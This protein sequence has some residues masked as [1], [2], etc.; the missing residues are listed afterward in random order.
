MSGCGRDGSQRERSASASVSP[1]MHQCIQLTSVYR[2]LR[3]RTIQSRTIHRW[4]WLRHSRRSLQSQHHPRMHHE[5]IPVFPSVAAE[6]SRWTRLRGGV[7]R[8]YM[9]RQSPRWTR[10]RG[11]GESESVHAFSTV[12]HAF[13]TVIHAFTT[14]PRSCRQLVAF[15][16]PNVR[17]SRRAHSQWRPC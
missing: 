16:R 5:Y 12:I 6:K 1:R 10:L 9:Q 8:R 4:C 14:Y 13:S 7:V 3:M 11:A 15:R 17:G 2:R